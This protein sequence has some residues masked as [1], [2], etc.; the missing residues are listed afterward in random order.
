MAAEV[1]LKVRTAREKVPGCNPLNPI[2]LRGQV[3][4]DRQ[5]FPRLDQTG[6]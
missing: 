2:V 4:G 5:P 6:S 3:W 1:S